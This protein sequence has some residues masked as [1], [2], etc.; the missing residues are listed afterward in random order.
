MCLYHKFIDL[1]ITYAELLMLV[2]VNDNI[3]LAKIN[4]DKWLHSLFMYGGW[5][6]TKTVESRQLHL[7]L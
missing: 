5:G 7:K 4:T 6:L 2:V 3:T 1:T